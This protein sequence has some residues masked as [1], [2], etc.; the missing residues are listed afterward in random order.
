M[1]LTVLVFALKC[2]P[3]PSIQTYMHCILSSGCF[4][5]KYLARMPAL[6]H[7]DVAIDRAISGEVI[8]TDVDFKVSCKTCGRMLSE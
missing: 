6:E 3:D 4:K 5:D 8:K 1:K 7:K 2:S